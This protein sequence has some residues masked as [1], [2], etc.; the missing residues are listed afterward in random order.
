[1]KVSANYLFLFFFPCGTAHWL[2]VRWILTDL[3]VVFLRR[4]LQTKARPVLQNFYGVE[5]G[6]KVFF[7]LAP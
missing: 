2:L 4:E 1:M 5:L 6:V 3:R 7:S